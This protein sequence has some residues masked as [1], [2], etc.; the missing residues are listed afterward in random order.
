MPYPQL[1]A[2][3]RTT[4]DPARILDLATSLIPG[5]AARSPVWSRDWCRHVDHSGH[6]CAAYHG[7]W[8]YIVWFG[9]ATPPQ[10]QKTFYRDALA[11]LL[12]A[13]RRRIL[14]SGAADYNLPATAWWACLM[15][16]SVPDLTLIDICETPLNLSVWFAAQAGLPL[17]TAR[18]DTLD[19]RSAQP[20]DAILAHSF[21]GNFGPERW[22]DLIR[23]WRDLLAPGGRV[24]LVNRL[25]P[26]ATDLIR[27]TPAQVE[28]LR[29]RFLAAAE[30]RTADLPLP[31]ADIAALIDGFAAHNV[32][33]P[34][35]SRDDFIALFEAAGFTIASLAVDAA[36]A[37]A[38]STAA[39]PTLA[40]GVAY[41]K[42]VAVKR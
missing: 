25:R 8:P 32:V 11:E 40:G 13:G 20:Y 35:R 33:F 12:H 22:P 21:F 29:W 5:A 2:T 27:F 17:E 14:L 30:R 19:Y 3:R 38:P 6:D 41:L 23:A 9:L 34:L 42:L 31:L 18:A 15:A 7:I 26:E 39:G 37:S 1:V 16:G 10:L 36:V 28:D 24:V 4:T